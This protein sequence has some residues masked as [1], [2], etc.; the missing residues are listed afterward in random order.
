M[1]FSRRVLTAILAVL[2]FCTVLIATALSLMTNTDPHWYDYVS[3]SPTLYILASLAFLG[4]DSALSR[5]LDSWLAAIE[6]L[7]RS[8]S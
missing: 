1:E 7:F 4:S 8:S 5:E 2:A 3:A 6:R